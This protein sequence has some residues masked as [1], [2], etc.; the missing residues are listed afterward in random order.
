MIVK[1]KGK[2]ETN[3]FPQAVSDTLIAANKHR[4]IREIELNLHVFGKFWCLP[5]LP[6]WR[7][8]FNQLYLTFGP[9]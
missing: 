5:Y 6:P 4:P 7:E 8:Y 3:V 2:L 9:S 1:D